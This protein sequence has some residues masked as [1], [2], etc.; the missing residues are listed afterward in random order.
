[1]EPV[2][3]DSKQR[4]SLHRSIRAAVQHHFLGRLLQK[5]VQGKVLDAT[6][7]DP[8]SNH[9]LAAGR[10]TR[11]CDWRFVHRARLGVL[12]LNGCLLVPDR[13]RACRRCDWAFESTAHVLCHCQRHSRAWKNRHGAVLKALVDE[14]PQEKKAVL[15]VERTVRGTGSRL[16]PDMVLLDEEKKSA[17]IVDVCCPFESRREALA[18]ARAAKVAKYTPLVDSLQRRGYTAVCDAVV[19]GALGAWDPANTG[20]LS[21]LGIPSRRQPALKHKA[22]SGVIKW[23]RD[24]YVEHVSGHRQYTEDVTPT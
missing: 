15:T 10:H 5:P 16:M 8:A 4:G 17:V 12:P 2:V 14:M 23:S 9:F 1:M 18:T 19:V 21:L 22:V 20:A 11:F 24:I 13:S 6:S 3:V 7:L